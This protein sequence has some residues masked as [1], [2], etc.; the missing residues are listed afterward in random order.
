MKYPTQRIIELQDETA[1][2]IKRQFIDYGVCG[3]QS[4]LGHERFCPLGVYQL[5]SN[6]RES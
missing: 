6:G 4:T 1:E 5:F 3:R 2:L